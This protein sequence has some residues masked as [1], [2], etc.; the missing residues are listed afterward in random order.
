MSFKNEIEKLLIENNCELLYDNQYDIKNSKELIIIYANA[1]LFRLFLLDT[2]SIENREKCNKEAKHSLRELEADKQL[3]LTDNVLYIISYSYNGEDIQELT[4]LNQFE[5]IILNSINRLQL[6]ENGLNKDWIK[7]IEHLSEKMINSNCINESNFIQRVN[8]KLLI[9]STKPIVNYKS[10]SIKFLYENG[11]YNF[12]I[13]FNIPKKNIP[14][15]EDEIFCCKIDY[16]EPDKIYDYKF[17]LPKGH[18]DDIPYLSSSFDSK[19]NSIISNSLKS[20][21]IQSC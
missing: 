15:R 14:E 16:S 12:S 18:Y 13:S 20:I 8:L 4:N 3:F 6:S 5:E 7:S 10:F 2:F 11:N 17:L 9:N 1:I 19:V 21:I